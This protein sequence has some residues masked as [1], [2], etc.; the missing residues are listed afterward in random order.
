[1]RRV[2]GPARGLETAPIAAQEQPPRLESQLQVMAAERAQTLR[3]RFACF[4]R[5]RGSIDNDS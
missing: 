2:N 4:A 1:M 3:Q 5:E